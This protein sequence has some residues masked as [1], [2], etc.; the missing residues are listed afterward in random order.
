MP[1]TNKPDTSVILVCAGNASRMN[2]VNK[3]LMPLG[4]SNVIGICMQAFQ[5]CED[6]AEI[7]IVTKSEHAQA[8]RETAESLQISKLTQ[9]TDGG[10]T[11]QESVMQGL[12]LVSKFTN[13]IA[14]H[15]G[16]RPLVKPEHISKVI[17]DA[18]VFGG[19]TLGVPVKDTIKI[20]DDGLI[21]DTPP[22]HTLYITQTP[23]VF[24]KRLYFEAVDFAL[25][26]HLDFTDD[27]Q[28]V[29]SIGGKVCMTTGDYTNI[30]I[31]TP[32]DRAIAEVLL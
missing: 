6:V 23:Q 1:E 32:E 26:H 22:R 15:D 5:Q 27:C 8:I 12:K 4:K 24:R 13:Y 31:T 21:T 17:R 30:K 18:R 14:V 25:E 19:A 11:R 9:I 10:A 20:V 16:A 29:E 2:G 3:I 28:L 7:I